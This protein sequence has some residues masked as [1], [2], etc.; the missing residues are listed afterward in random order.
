MKPASNDWN[1]IPREL[2]SL[3]KKNT[4]KTFTLNFFWITR[5]TRLIGLLA[6]RL[7]DLKFLLNLVLGKIQYSLV[8]L[9]IN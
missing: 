2:K 6:G 5:I 9:R 8:E 7:S 4:C 1:S 3:E